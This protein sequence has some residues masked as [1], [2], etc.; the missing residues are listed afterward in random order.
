MKQSGSSVFAGR[1]VRE[2]QSG[3]SLMAVAPLDLMC[4]RNLSLRQDAR[5]VWDHSSYSNRPDGPV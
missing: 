5:R 4:S 2:L 1:Q 3:I